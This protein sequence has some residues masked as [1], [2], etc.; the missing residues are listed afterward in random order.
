MTATEPRHIADS[1]PGEPAPNYHHVREVVLNWPPAA[2]AQL[3]HDV[4]NQLAGE[5]SL[6]QKHTSNS[7]AEMVSSLLRPATAEEV[8]ERI[9]RGLIKEPPPVNQRNSMALYGLLA[10]E[11][12]TPTEEQVWQMIDDERWERYN[13]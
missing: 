2:Q 5:D 9:A 10:H 11:G 4:I 13:R 6:A 3:V 12:S 7:D 1:T 8:E